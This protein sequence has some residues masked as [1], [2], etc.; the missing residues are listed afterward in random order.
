MTPLLYYKY[1]KILKEFIRN[2]AKKI[3]AV[4]NGG[5]E[6]DTRM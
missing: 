4:A 6:N 1:Y 5:L 2:I 3:V